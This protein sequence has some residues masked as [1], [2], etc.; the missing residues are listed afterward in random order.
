MQLFKI[1]NSISSGLSILFSSV[2]EA[3]KE[4]KDIHRRQKGKKEDSIDKNYCTIKLILILILFQKPISSNISGNI[5]DKKI[6]Q[7]L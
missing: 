1:E 2:D 6:T 4:S 5:S 3:F 7:H